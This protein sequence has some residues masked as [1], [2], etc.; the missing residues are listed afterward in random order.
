MPNSHQ[1]LWKSIELLGYHYYSTQGFRILVSLIDNSAYDFVIEKDGCFQRV[2]VK[3]AGVKDNKQPNSWSI[4]VAGGPTRRYRAAEDTVK[5]KGVTDIYLVWLPTQG[6]FIE[7][8]GNFFE[9]SKSTSKRIPKE[10]I[11]GRLSTYCF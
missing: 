11:A 4:G 5:S 1:P 2:N 7:L 8:S 3:M 10:L 6:G 9:G